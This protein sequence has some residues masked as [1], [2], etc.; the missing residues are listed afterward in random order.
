MK[1]R[2]CALAIFSWAV[3]ALVGCNGSN[4]FD[5]TTELSDESS[6]YDISESASSSPMSVDYTSEE[7]DLYNSSLSETIEY[8][9]DADG[10]YKEGVKT[11][12][13]FSGETE[14]YCQQHYDEIQ[15]II[16]A[17]EEDI[18]KGSASRH[19]CEECSKEGVYELIGFSGA[20]EYYCTEHYSQ[21]VEILEILL[22]DYN[23]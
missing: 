16:S 10:C 5:N 2:V 7:S 8:Y 22:E 4:N 18:G 13:G 15:D 17:M 3:M 1:K 19:Q 12:T 20:T 21:L 14:Y 23:E 9:C 11:M 6:S